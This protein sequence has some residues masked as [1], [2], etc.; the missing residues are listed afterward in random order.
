MSNKALIEL[1][2]AIN[3]LSIFLSDS[4]LACTNSTCVMGDVVLA[5]SFQFAHC[6]HLFPNILLAMPIE[7]G[8]FR[9]SRLLAVLGNP[10][11]RSYKSVHIAGTNGKG[12]TIAYLSSILT[13]AKIRNGRFTSPHLL[14][15][16]DCISINNETYSRAKFERV[17]G[18]VSLENDR[19]SLGCTEFELLT[20]T[21]F[22]IF[23][24]EKIEL[25]LVEV[26]VGGRLDATNVLEAAQV[27][28]VEMS[29]G[30]VISGI[31]KIGMD[32]VSLLGDTLVKIAEEK[33]GIIKKL[34]P[35]VVDSTNEHSVLLKI[36][37]I[38]S[39]LASDVIIADAQKMESIQ[40][41]LKFSPLQGDYQ[42]NNLAVSITI[43]EWLQK[44]SQIPELSRSTITEGIR[45]TIWAGRLQRIFDEYTGILALID[46]AHNRAAA[47]E[48]GKYLRTYRALTNSKGLILVVAQSHGKSIDDLLEPVCDKTNDTVI[49]TRFTQPKDMPWV[50]SD[51]EEFIVEEA[52]RH[53]NDVRQFNNLSMEEIFEALNSI[54][55]DGDT[56]PIIFCGSL[57]LCSDVLRYIRDGPQKQERAST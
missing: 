1:S 51:T 45:N 3:P 38:A 56:R 10:Q 14:E 41:F 13:L 33:A 17:H 16:H 20:A 8:L 11:A 22:K 52:P 37:G 50:F 49:A 46:G 18:D 39:H 4:N 32:H 43:L 47:N 28:D 15:P 2:K 29:G 31:T 9:I 42:A 24:I 19:H 44:T 55:A 27:D 48:L 40:D 12:S 21:A 25:A 23:E 26:G 36:E 53:V 5:G 7:L 34:V 57:Y 54:R 35:V 6:I 30:V